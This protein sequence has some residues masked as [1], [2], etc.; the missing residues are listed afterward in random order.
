MRI[1]SRL[2]IA[3]ILLVSVAAVAACGPLPRQDPQPHSNRNGD[4]ANNNKGAMEP[5]AKHPLAGK[6]ITESAAWKRL[7]IVT[8]GQSG[9]DRA[10][11][12]VALALDLPVRGW[13]PKDRLAEDGRIPERYPLQETASED[14]ALRT[15][16]NAWD[17]DG[18][19]VLSK[20]LPKD[21]TPL[22]EEV[23]KRYGKPFLYIDLDAEPTDT[24][25]TEFRRWV[26]D[27]NIRILNIGGPRESHQPG[28]I[29][30]RAR[31]II[32]RLL[33]K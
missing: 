30:A 7:W 23:A 27:N 16:L 25:V 21:G 28:V 2:V 6:Y 22:T 10:A 19:L 11:L 4:A 24:T 32:E 18:T 3:G 12:D 5:K 14:P 1:R 29:Y 33:R 8:G 20:G 17:S 15:E 9:V 13:C 26:Q 31:Q